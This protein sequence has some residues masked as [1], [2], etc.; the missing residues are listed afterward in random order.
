[1]LNKTLITILIIVS[2]LLTLAQKSGISGLVYNNQN[3][4]MPY[5]TVSLLHP[6]DSSFA[7]FTITDNQGGFKMSNAKNGAYLLQIAFVGYKTHYEKVNLPVPENLQTRKFLIEQQAQVLGEVAVTDDLV[8]VL[9]K[10]DTVEY[11]AGAFKTKPGSV[12]ED[13]LK[14]LPGVE[15]DRAGNI[16]AMGE[17][18]GKVLVDGKEFFSNDPK[19][20]TKNLPAESVDKVQVYNDKSDESEM[21]GIDDSDYQKTINLKLKDGMKNMIF[22][23]LEGGGGY[24]KYYLG[25]TKLYR[26]TDKHQFAALA[27]SNNISKP[28]FSLQDYMDFNGGLSNLMSGDGNIELTFD[29]DGPIPVDFGQSIQGDLTTGAGGVNYSYEL[30]KDNRFNIS[31]MGNGSIREVDNESYTRNYTIDDMFEQAGFSSNRKTDINHLINFG[32]RNRS[33]KKQF[34]MLNGVATLYNMRNT[35]YEN[36]FNTRNGLYVNMLDQHGTSKTEKFA[37]S[38]KGSYLRKLGGFMKLFKIGGEVAVDQSLREIDERISTYFEGDADTLTQLPFQQNDTRSLS[39]SAYVKS[40]ARLGNKFYVE[41]GLFSG[42]KNEIRERELLFPD[43]Q[44]ADNEIP[45][46]FDVTYQYVK[47]RLELKK[48]INKHRL[49]AGTYWEFGEQRNQPIDTTAITNHSNEI[50]PFVRWEYEYRTGHRI[51]AGFNSRMRQPSSYELQPVISNTNALYLFYGNRQLRSEI[52]QSMH[53][54]WMLFDQFSFTSLFV[55]LRGT[56]TKNK[57]NRSIQIFDD[58]SQ[59]VSLINVP[60]DYYLGGQVDF[61]THIKPLKIKISTKYLNSYNEGISYVNQMKNV[62]KQYSHKGKLSIENR[63]KDKFDLRI[64]ASIKWTGVNY[65]LQNDLNQDYL[66]YVGFFDFSYTPTK[67]WLFSLV[68]DL[69]NYHSN[70]FEED[71][72]VPIIELGVQH[73]FMENNRAT[74]ALKCFDLLDMNKGIDRISSYNYLQQNQS[75]TVGRFIMLTLKYRLNKVAKKGGVFIEKD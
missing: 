15:V 50:L 31:Y 46:Q 37:L 59:L 9:V 7:Y 33:N 47:P 60:E 29:S 13:I 42:I 63:K 70:G 45:S 30:K 38:A 23:H 5:A 52:N 43:I 32:W 27:M 53:A 49:Y 56:Y 51:T 64:G 39:T 73:H 34:F 18:V 69:T 57:I 67:R 25:N 58:L 74:I 54:S 20:A 35:S 3:E 16:K 66:E 2:P 1:M 22:G 61:S 8:P 17:N 10:R 65:S 36:Y 28:G 71:V 72:F 24:D 19:V 68:S 21:L 55:S 14:Q 41:T 75:N 62:N 40:V 12:A 48:Y 11:N 4:P 44:L 6:V 26:F